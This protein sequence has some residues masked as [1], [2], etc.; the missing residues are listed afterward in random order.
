MDTKAH[1]SMELKVNGMIRRVTC[2]AEEPLLYV[3]RNQLGLKGPRFGCGL[4]QCGA[5]TVHM[6]GD[7]L[8]SCVFP[9]RSV[10][11]ADVTTL[12]RLA[13]AEELHPVQRAFVDEQAAQCGYC[14]NGWIMTA[15]AVL[16]EK[17]G[18]SDGELKEALSGLKCRCGTH[19]SL[20]RAV[21]RAA[22]EMANGGVS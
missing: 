11:T 4:G 17:P 16:K 12:E 1:E 2:D 14:I 13:K 10:G 7:A 15:A 5:C 20:F 3:L 22:R 6:D 21:K 18:A 8:R 9:A 19:L